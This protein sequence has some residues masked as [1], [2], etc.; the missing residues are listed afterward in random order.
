[1]NYGPNQVRLNVD[2]ISIYTK[3]YVTTDTE[4]VVQIYLGREKLKVRRFG[5]DAMMEQESVHIGY[6]AAVTAHL[7][8]TDRK[9]IGVT[10]ILDTGAVVSVMPIKT[11]ERMG[12]TREDLIPTKLSLAAPIAEPSTWQTK[13]QLQSS[14]W[15]DETSG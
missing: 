10:G 13:F 4:Q 6:E 7:L 12:F 15:E 5:H 11:S 2:V 9:K 14:I 1:M 8:D 3:N